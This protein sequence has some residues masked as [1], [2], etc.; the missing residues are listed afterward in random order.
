VHGDKNAKEVLSEGVK[1]ALSQK[2]K[3]S[4]VVCV[5]KNLEI[6]L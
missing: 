5:N 1:A 4:K 3:T 6:N 2:C